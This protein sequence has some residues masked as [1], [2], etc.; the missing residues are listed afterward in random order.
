MGTVL[1]ATMTAFLVV[2]TVLVGVIQAK[3]FLVETEDKARK[4]YDYSG[5][6]TT[7]GNG[8]RSW[9]YSTT[10]TEGYADS[11]YKTTKGN[12]YRSGYQTTKGNGYRSGY[13]TTRGNGYRSGYYGTTKKEYK[14]RI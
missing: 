7:K 11:G 3:H 14:K 8:Y 2:L 13:Q 1:K 9:Y 4:E 10:T 6:Q 5:Y 12:V